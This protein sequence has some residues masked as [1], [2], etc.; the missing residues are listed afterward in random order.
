M[1]YFDTSSN[2]EI[3]KAQEQEQP[4]AF[5]KSD[6]KPSKLSGAFEVHLNKKS[7][8]A[9]SPC[10]LNGI[11]TSSQKQTK[12]GDLVDLALNQCIDITIKVVRVGDIEQVKKSDGT[13]LSKQDVIVSD[14]TGSIRLVLWESDINGL[15]LMSGVWPQVWYH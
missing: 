4:L 15:S 3:E 11:A 7:A 12:L 5:E 6:I 8:Q 1:V 9:S 10:K 14:N 2:S 13:E